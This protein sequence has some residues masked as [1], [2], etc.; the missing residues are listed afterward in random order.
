MMPKFSF[1]KAGII[2]FCFILTTERCASFSLNLPLK[3]STTTTIKT[4]NKFSS[5]L[6][7]FAGKGDPLR[8]ATGIRPSLHPTTINAISEALL[9]RARQSNAVKDDDT[10]ITEGYPLVVNE[11][12][13]IKP[14]DVAV[15]AGRLA[16]DAISKRTDATLK[17]IEVEGDKSMIFNEQECQVLAGRVVGVVMRFKELEDLLIK[18]VNKVGWIEKYNEYSTFGV[19]KEECQDDTD[20]ALSSF[21]LNNEIK[22]N[23]LLRMSRAECLLALFIM[24]EEI[25]KMRELG[26]ETVDSDRALDF[27]DSD[28][29]EVLSGN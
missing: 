26:Q 3:Y 27:L 18:S 19:L 25:P 22:M 28:R 15:A 24:T 1:F 4:A 6:I 17:N 2:C 13:G 21:E 23:P 8:A 7:L 5:N 16:T 9:V 11:E 20:N 10:T 14:I 29:Y 12:K